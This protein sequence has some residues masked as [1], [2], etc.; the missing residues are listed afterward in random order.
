MRL[1]SAICL[2]ALF[3]C[4]DLKQK[5]QSLAECQLDVNG[6]KGAT[7]RKNYAEAE[8]TPSGKDGS[9]RQFMLTCMEAKGFDFSSP[10]DEKGDVNKACWTEDNKGLVPDSLVDES[11]CYKSK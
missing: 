7:Y 8:F 9:Y 3:G 5:E 6:P 10:L 4:S 11:S 1:V 2:L